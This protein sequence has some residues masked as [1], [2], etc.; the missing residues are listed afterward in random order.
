MPLGHTLGHMGRDGG[1]RG[2][3]YR[4]GDCTHK[5]RAPRVIRILSDMKHSD[6]SDR[7]WLAGF[8]CI[9]AITIAI[10]AL[11]VLG[12]H[13]GRASAEISASGTTGDIAT[14]K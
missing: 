2:G 1:A 11:V 8:V 12:L 5:L 6:S 4:A 3:G 9:A 13:G 7:V 10:V 14:D